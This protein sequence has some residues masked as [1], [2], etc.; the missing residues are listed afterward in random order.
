VALAVSREPSV[1]ASVAL[2]ETL[3]GL[4]RNWSFLALGGR[5][6]MASRPAQFAD[7]AAARSWAASARRLRGPALDLWQAHLLRDQDGGVAE[8]LGATFLAPS[9]WPPIDMQAR[10]ATI[11]HPVTLLYG[12]SSALSGDQQKAIAAYFP[13]TRVI[14]IAGAGHDLHL[15]APAALAAILVEGLPS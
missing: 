15:D 2:A 9:H 6:V 13:R 10:L 11:A 3:V 14:Q 12:S 5:R 7:V 4:E 8:K 1:A